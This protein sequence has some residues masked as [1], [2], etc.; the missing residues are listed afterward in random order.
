M[1]RL[2]SDAGKYEFGIQWHHHYS[3]KALQDQV[4]DILSFNREPIICTMENGP[5]CGAE[6]RGIHTCTTEISSQVTKMQDDRYTVL[7]Q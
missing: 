3:S 4:V 2:A 7:S 1:A 5:N 6:K